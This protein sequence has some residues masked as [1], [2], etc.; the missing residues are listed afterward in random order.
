ML[1]TVATAAPLLWVLT[2][3][4]WVTPFG[5]KLVLNRYPVTRKD[6]FGS[7]VLGTG[8]ALAGTCPGAVLM[9]IGGGSILG[10]VPMIGIFVGLALRGWV[11]GASTGRP[12]QVDA[13]GGAVLPLAE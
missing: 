11:V 13:P 4:G 9:M 7:A 1:S 8:W 2:R 3:L 6:F 10:L 5:G 12:N